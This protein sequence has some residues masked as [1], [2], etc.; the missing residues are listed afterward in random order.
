MFVKCRIQNCSGELPSGVKDRLQPRGIRCAKE[1][2]ETNTHSHRLSL[3]LTHTHKTTHK[4]THTHTHTHIHTPYQQSLIIPQQQSLT[5]CH[6]C[7]TV[8][9]VD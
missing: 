7:V 2:T 5:Q 8:L 4:H 6:N 1:V 3:S 9:S